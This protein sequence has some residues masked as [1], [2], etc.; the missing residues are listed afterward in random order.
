MKVGNQKCNSVQDMSQEL[1]IF[2]YF[3]YDTILSQENLK[4]GIFFWL[5]SC[6]SHNY[7]KN[8]KISF[9]SDVLHPY[10]MF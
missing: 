2:T 1:L 9:C 6:K 4:D 10:D 8:R 3:N 7:T 5:T